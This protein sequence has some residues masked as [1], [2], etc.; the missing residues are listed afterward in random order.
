VRLKLE[1]GRHHIGELRE[2]VS[3][4][5]Q[6]D[7]YRI[8]RREDEL[9]DLVYSVEVRK[10]LPA[11]LAAIA[12]DAIHNTRSA[13]DLLCWQLVVASGGAPDRRTAFPM[14][15]TEQDFDRLAR[16]CLLG[17][18]SRAVC[19]IKRLKPWPGGNEAL[20]QLHQLDIIDKHRVILVVGGAHRDVVLDFQMKVPWQDEPI[21]VPPLALRPADRQF[22]L[23]DG[24]ELYRVMAAARAG[25]MHGEPLFTFEICFAEEGSVEG[26]PIVPTLERIHDHVHR[27]VQI[28]DRRL[29]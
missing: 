9:G 24:A 15:Q 26:L 19:F 17:A 1:R 4:H 13:L 18:S 11:E 20:A 12:G 8:I 10:E 23:A 25:P 22:P 27:I 5:V 16:R 14:P 29:I 28:A 7:P 21:R 2:M 3:A 6:S